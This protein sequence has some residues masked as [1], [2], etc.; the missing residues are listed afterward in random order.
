MSH[1]FSEVIL[2]CC[3]AAQETF[4]IMNVEIGVLI[5]IFVIAVIHYH[6]NVGLRFNNTFIQQG[7][8]K[9]IK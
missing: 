7:G 4:H 5:H 8:I 6:S 3:F 2:I 9:L 1:D